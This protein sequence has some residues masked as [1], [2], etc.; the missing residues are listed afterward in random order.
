MGKGFDGCVDCEG[1]R[2]I[3]RGFPDTRRGSGAR[4]RDWGIKRKGRT[5]PGGWTQVYT[6][7][8]IVHQEE[9]VKIIIYWR[10]DYSGEKRGRKKKA[11][12]HFLRG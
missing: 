5:G 2:W 6:R 1:F 11:Q 3:W 7:E 10:M 9:L 8:S 4:L 12:N